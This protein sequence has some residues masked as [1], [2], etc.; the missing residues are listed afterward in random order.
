MN[1]VMS[2]VKMHLLPCAPEVCQQCA[3]DHAPEAAHNALSIYYQYKFYGEHG[4]WPTWKDAIAHCS[5][6]VQAFWEQELRKMDAW[7]E[8]SEEVPTANQEG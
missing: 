3:V 7:T 5:P 1:V 2:T 6:E 8:P 4:R